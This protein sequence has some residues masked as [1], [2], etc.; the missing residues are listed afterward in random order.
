MKKLIIS[1][2]IWALPVVALAA[3]MFSW[4][5][6][7]TNTDGTPL[8]DLAGNK[9]YCGLVSGQYTIIKDAGLP[10]LAGK[11]ALYPTGNVIIKD[12]SYYCAITAYDTHN[13]ESAKSNEA[14]Y[15]LDKTPPG[16]ATGFGVK[17][18]AD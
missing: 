17:E 6:P 1:L 10:A 5:Q 12:G 3:A 11:E 2:F 8:L 18:I 14:L 13:N 7:S 9:V 16:A 4:T 15:F